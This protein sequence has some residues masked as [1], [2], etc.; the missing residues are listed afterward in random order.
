MPRRVSSKKKHS[1]TRAKGLGAKA[2]TMH[3]RSVAA[4][5]HPKSYRKTKAFGTFGRNEA[6]FARK[7][8]AIQ[9]YQG[10]NIAKIRQRF[11][12]SQE[13]LGRV[14][15]Y[16]T[17][18]IAGWEK[19]KAVSDSAR[20]KL[21]ETERLR[22]ALSNIIP[23]DSLAQW[24]RAPNPAFENQTPIQVMERG[25]SDRLWRM[26]FQIDANVAN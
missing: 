23:P 1:S 5:V 10:L 21:Y 6:T 4:G 14:T 7:F 26:I 2:R 3:A 12:V 15:G 13:E 22:E 8:G 20:Q 24:L 25:E 18:S 19:G 16:S 11:G 9:G 17:R